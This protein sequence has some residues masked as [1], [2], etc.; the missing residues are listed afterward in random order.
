MKKLLFALFTAIC[1]SFVFT[2]CSNSADSSDNGGSGKKSEKTV[3]ALDL[4]NKLTS[5]DR[6]AIRAAE[7]DDQEETNGRV[8]SVIAWP[9]TY[10]GAPVDVLNGSFISLKGKKEGIEITVT[11]PEGFQDKKFSY[12]Q[13][14][15]ID[16]N[17]NDST[18]AT[19]S[20]TVMNKD[21]KVNPEFTF[22]YPFTKPGDTVKLRI[23]GAL[24]PDNDR[25]E[26]VTKTPSIGGAG[27]I[28]D[29]PEDFSENRIGGYSEWDVSTNKIRIHDVIL[30]DGKENKGKPAINIWGT[31]ANDGSDYN[32]QIIYEADLDASF[33]PSEEAYIDLAKLLKKTPYTG[34]KDGQPVQ[35]YPYV[36][37][38]FEYR[39]AGYEN[40]Y[41]RI[42]SPQIYTN[43][44]VK[45]T[46]FKTSQN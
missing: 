42:N 38:Q 7:N 39:Y 37:C 20:D 29:L 34:I 1:I 23:Q 36:F 21:G 30:E 15:Y 43:P 25:I 31:T 46:L 14:V 45:N 32:P 3:N 10:A 11:C 41:W 19:V 6:T 18:F 12:F 16:N 17:D 28:D 5:S 35:D 44:P 26:L 40:T 2:A 24:S 27:V 22:I 9:M 33:D 4:R 8:E 13:V